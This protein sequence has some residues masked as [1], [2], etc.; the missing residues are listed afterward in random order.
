MCVQS[1]ISAY[2]RDNINATAWTQKSFT[3]FKDV[4]KQAEKFDIA[5]NQPDCDTD[6]KTEWM[7]AVEER[8]D[9]M[10]KARLIP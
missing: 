10:E 4:L 3:Q 7:K 2:G 8:L 1:V 6:D 9:A 5:A